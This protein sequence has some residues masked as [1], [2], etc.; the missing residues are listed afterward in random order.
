MK[1]SRIGFILVAAVCAFSGCTNSSSRGGIK[2]SSTT[3]EPTTSITPEPGPEPTP[4]VDPRNVPYENV[5]P[6]YDKYYADYD[7]QNPLGDDLKLEVHKYFI[8]E[9]K[10]Y[11]TYG[12]FWYY[13]NT[14]SD[15]IP[16]TDTNELFYTGKT[17]PRVNRDRI[18]REH[19]WAC[20]RSANLW[21]RYNTMGDIPVEHNIDSSHQ[22]KY[23]GGGSDLYHVRPASGTSINQK[24]SDAPFYDFTDEELEQ[25]MA[26]GR[27]SK[28]TDG[29]K[30]PCYVDANKN[31]FEVADEFKGDV[32]RILM[33]LW[34]HYSLIGSENVYYSPE[35]T[36][37][38]SLDEAVKNEDGHN[39]NVCGP[40]SFSSIMAFDEDECYLRLVE[41]NQIDPPSQVEVNRNN[42]VQT[43]QG[44]RNP[45]VD[46]PQLMERILFE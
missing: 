29:G 27:V 34:V 40:L 26:Q 21:V 28:L 24:R 14:A 42:Y 4:E 35:H 46:Y 41:W 39:P 13:A 44:N 45:F 43:V 23:W 22:D 36:P 11:V 10:T 2:P 12:D 3:S 18:D 30:Y 38:Y 17:S 33:Y 1:N 19:V 16:G 7:F 20:A 32:A 9:H 31:K 5:Y 37:V 8:R 6:D 15:L 25:Q